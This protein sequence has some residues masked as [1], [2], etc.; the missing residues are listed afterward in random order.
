MGVHDVKYLMKLRYVGTAFCGSQIQ[1]NVR[2]VQGVLNDAFEALFGVRCRVTSCSRTDSG[3]HARAASLTVELPDGTTPIP[4]EKLPL[5][6]APHLPGD[7]AVF[8]AELRPDDFHVRHDVKEKEYV[9]LVHNGTVRDPHL[10]HR[11][12]FYPT[13]IDE[14]GLARMQAALPHLLGEHDFAAFMAQGSPVATTVRTLTYFGVV[15]E[16]ETLRFTVRGDGFLY[17]MVRILVGTLVEVAAGRIAPDEIPAVI[18]SCDRRRAGMT[19]PPDG[20]YLNRVMY[21]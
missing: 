15:R 4:A 17:N 5:A 2:T 9:Y 7:V 13:P 1:P 11:A 16:G 20:L 3:V 8:D 6:V 10:E 21:D 19:A 12:W 14:T 18:A